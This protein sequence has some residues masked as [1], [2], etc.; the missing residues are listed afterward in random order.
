MSD[1]AE[2]APAAEIH[3]ADKT[4][5]V[6]GLGNMGLAIA[7]RLTA[8][9]TVLGSDLSPQRQAEALAL[10]IQVVDSAE[11]TK[12]CT[13]IVLSLPHPS[14][15]LSVAEAIGRAPGIVTAV[16]E[17]STVTPRDIARTQAALAGGAVNLV[18][19]AILA[20]V[21]QMRA[22]TA[23]LVLSGDEAQI[24]A[25]QPVFDALTPKQTV[26]GSSGNAMAAKVINNAVAHVVM[27]L[28]SE[29]VAMAEASGLDS[30]AIV[31]ILASPDG[32]LMRPLTHRIGERVFT[33]QYE[34][35]MSLEAARKDS[36]LA[37]QLAH[38]EGIP[39]FTIPAAHA[40]YEM[41]LAQGWAREDYAALAKL[42]ENWADTS[43]VRAHRTT[44]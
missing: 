10:G 11:L 36:V 5:G 20:G 26:L 6:I 9:Y 32:G 17:T 42:W 24:I 41:A 7:E 30:Q 22:G 38:D 44:E 4:I 19:A 25:L 37:Q 31:D 14:A 23:G 28:L 40:V 12:R 18:D 21:A 16:V 13:T 3:D 43:F 27:V 34:G 33:G 1:A 35:G 39:I 8:A 29:A 2:T 15:S